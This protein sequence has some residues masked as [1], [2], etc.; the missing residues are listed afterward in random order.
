MRVP[1][2]LPEIGLH[3]G[4]V[5]GPQVPRQCAQQY[6]VQPHRNAYDP[7]VLSARRRSRH[8]AR[9]T[10]CVRSAYSTIDRSRVV[11]AAS[12]CRPSGVNA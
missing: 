2:V 12:T 11:S 9:R 10:A 8:H 6:A 1:R 7:R 3:G 4:A 5:L